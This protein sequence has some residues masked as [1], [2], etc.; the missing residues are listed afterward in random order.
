METFMVPTTD[1]TIPDTNLSSLLVG[2]WMVYLSDY[3]GD[4]TIH[5]IVIRGKLYDDNSCRQP[6]MGQNPLVRYMERTL[7]GTALFPVLYRT[8][9]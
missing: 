4:L 3:L 1:F 8:F 7:L 5:D 9:L 6:S 2:P